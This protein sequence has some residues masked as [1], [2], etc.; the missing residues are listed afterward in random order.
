MKDINQKKN[1]D[2]NDFISKNFRRS[3]FACRCGCGFADIDIKLV[4]VLEEIR[5]ISKSPIII[6]SGC[7][8]EAHNTRV[9]G[10]KESQHVKGK[11]VDIKIIGYD[12]QVVADHIEKLYPYC[13]GIGRYSSWVHIDI[14]P[15]KVR[16][17]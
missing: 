11:A 5:S 13:Y 3:E 9:G 6:T 4:K 16:W 1:E 12:S 17:G 10:A 2:T 8:C 14:R 7:R 15:E